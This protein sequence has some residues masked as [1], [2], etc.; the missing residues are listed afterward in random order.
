MQKKFKGH[1]PKIL[2]VLLLFFAV[3]FVSC[4]EDLKQN[5][6]PAYLNETE[7]WHSKR[8][9]NLRK[10]NSWLNLV[11]LYWLKPG[12]N[13]FGSAKD[14]DIVFPENAPK[15]IGSF[16]LRD[17]IVTIKILPNVEVFQDT[18][19]INEIEMQND[20]LGNPTTLKLD[21]FRWFIIKRGEKFAVRLRDLNAA[22]LKEFSGIERFPVN[23]DW[24]FEAKYLPYN[25]SKKIMVPN[26]L[27][28]SDEETVSGKL[29]F[30]RDK[31]NYSLEPIDSGDR[32]FIIFAD[33]TNG[34]STYGAGRFLY[35]DKPDS[36]GIVILDFNKSY[37]PPCVFTK[38]ATCPL[39]PEQNHLA[40]KIT[41][42]EKS[43]GQGH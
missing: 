3:I 26:V 40:I 16:T 19:I 9:A 32:L 12:E 24:R 41:A 25:P 36:S 34:E 43:Y 7:Q 13:K 33:E 6:D 28:G 11:G 2:M 10:E 42:G 15:Y 38:Y 4:E 21:G 31:R 8:I 39:P 20:L 35:A 14:N 22:L 29:I 27:G 5:A 17:S 30:N 37:N 1:R 23:K 18:F